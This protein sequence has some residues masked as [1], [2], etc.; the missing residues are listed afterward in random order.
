CTFSGN[1]AYFGGGIYNDGNSGNAS[2]YISACTFSRNSANDSGGGIYNGA[3][4]GNATLKVLDST[5]STNS[6]QYGGG[7][8]SDGFYGSAGLSVNASTFSGNSA[9]SVG[10]GSIY[11][12]GFNGTATVQ[13]GDTILSAGASSAP[14]QNDG[15]TVA[16]LGYNLSSDNGGGFLTATTDQVNT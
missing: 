9:I 12:I 16:S 5:F 13:I 10:G 4:A 6:A 11:N 8:Y 1:S 14:L 7:I 3:E 15:G 2:L